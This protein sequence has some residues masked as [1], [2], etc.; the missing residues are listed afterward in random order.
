MFGLYETFLDVR[1]AFVNRS[2]DAFFFSFSFFL[3]TESFEATPKFRRRSARLSQRL[4][5]ESS[6]AVVVVLASIE[7]ASAVGGGYTDS[8]RL[9]VAASDR[10]CVTDPPVR[11]LGGGTLS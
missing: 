8:C 10:R 6:S 3:A 9:I 11:E 7:I 1:G 5:R 2:V 4:V